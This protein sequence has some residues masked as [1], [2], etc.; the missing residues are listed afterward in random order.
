MKTYFIKT[1]GCQMNVSD[2]ERI[3]GFLENNK[4][5]PTSKIEEADLVV[6]NTCGVRQMAEN[7]AYGQIH[8]LRKNNPNIKIVLTGCLSNRKDVRRRLQN[9]VDLFCEIKNFP[10]EI[11][12][13]LQTYQLQTSFNNALDQYLKIKPNYTNHYSANIPIMTGCN[14][15]CAYCVVPYARGRETSRSNK[16]IIAEIKSLI[17]DGYKSVTLLGQNVNSYN[18]GLI[19]FP[20]L[21]KKINAI[22]GK[23]WINFVSSHPKDMSSELIE[24]IAQC[25][26]VCE[27]VHLP[28]QAGSDVVLEKMNRKYTAGHYLGLVKK[29]KSAF[30]KYKPESLFALT[31]DIIV[32]FPG[33]TKR[34]FLESARLMEKVGYDMVYFG[35]F[36]PRPGTAAWNMKD[37]VSKIEKARR[38]KYLNAILERTT[39]ANNKKYLRKTL[40]VLIEK[41]KDGFYFGKT[42]TLK[43]VKFPAVKKNLV[44]KII[45]AKIIQANIWNIEGEI[46]P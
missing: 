27:L 26:K 33:E 22:P 38:E 23:F 34:Q 35:Q 9:K 17:K 42:R 20:K 41:E 13:L 45:K 37:N 36:S 32:G 40:E 43:N 2:S 1:F 8:N 31:S 3:D 30:K 5:K 46:L 12:K 28:I 15:F 11:T 14:N 21:L 10:S 4:Y 29:I 25:K 7:R 16:E 24:T 44:G 6:F 18:D 19:D 39:L